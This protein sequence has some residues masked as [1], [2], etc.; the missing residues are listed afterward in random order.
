MNVPDMEE[1]IR[2]A[3][4]V[5]TDPAGR[6]VEVLEDRNAL[7]I[8]EACGATVQE[9]Y[10]A[11]LRIGI[12]PYRYLR[13]RESLST[14]DQLKLA[15]SKVTVVGAGGLGGGIIL[16]LARMGVG[17]LVVVDKDVFDETNLNRQALSRMDVIGRSKAEVAAQTVAAINAGVT[18]TVLQAPFGDE[19]ALEILSGSDVAVDG[20]DNVATRRIL[21]TATQKLGIPLVHGAL[22]GFEGQMMTVF[23][24][25]PGMKVLYGSGDNC[26]P[27]P[28]RPEAVL[29]V[30]TITPAV[31]GAFQAME[32]VKI[33]LKKGRVFRKLMIHVDLDTGQWN[34]FMF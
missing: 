33:L 5:V 27:N 31:I 25:D 21:D 11:A 23:P 19:N 6:R 26:P 3:A 18:V 32:V 29:G 15:E 13:N 12:S 30:P 24:G 14:A 9:V 1:R 7:K 2:E 20:L 10:K 22:A 8:G 16:L 17:H 28:N 4:R 34:E